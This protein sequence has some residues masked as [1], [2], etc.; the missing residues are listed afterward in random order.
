MQDTSAGQYE[1]LH[2]L[3]ASW[4]GHS[5]T[6][7]LV[8]DP[9]QSIYLFRQARV[10]SFLQ[11]LETCRLGDLPLTR[12]QLTAN[13][14]SQRSLVDHFNRD[15]ALVFPD[16]D[17]LP[18]SAAE[19][20][21]PHSEHASGLKW[22]TNPV[23]IRPALP[24][25]P[26]SLLTPAQLRQRQAKRDACE[27]RRIIERW[28][29]KRLPLGREEPWKIAVLVRN[30]THLIE[31]TTEFDKDRPRPIPYRAID[32]VPLSVRQEVLDLTALT[33]TLLHPADRVAG[34]AV[35]RAPWCG[36]S[37]ADLHTLTGADDPSLR[38][39]SIRRLMSDRGHQLPQESIDRLERTWTVL[40]SV[41]TQRSRLSTARLVERAWRSLG[42]DTWHSFSEARLSNARRF[43][44]LLDEMDAEATSSGGALDPSRIA[45]RLPGLWAETN[46]C[47]PDA[48]SV[49]LLTIHRAK[50]LEWDVVLV[51]ALERRPGA[52]RSRLVTWSELDDADSTSA[53]GAPPI[54]L[55]PIA[56]KGEDVDLLTTW[57]KDIHKKRET[58]E[59]KRIFYVASTRAREELHLFAAPDLTSRGE[60]NPGPNSL[61]RFA[62]AAAKPHFDEWERSRTFD[63]RPWQPPK[64]PPPPA[65]QTRQ[66]HPPNLSFST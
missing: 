30:R 8:G 57:I 55:A 52:S 14:R 39:F 15:F 62:W 40:D 26:E 18:Y 7:F 28:S 9:R 10:E 50:G 54:L 23:E 22:H 6:V 60:L 46:P 12:L 4:D 17:S 47:P 20:I 24:L 37:L 19:A 42:G 59:Y 61:L 36:L 32:I 63:R 53:T 25:P 11:T 56:A 13:F 64:A 27:M 16:V 1:L 21:V 65:P 43:F 29:R 3:T 2:L 48:P 35:L 44:R 38:K 45:D 66:T 5:Q 51:P 34:L 58:A 31:I 49:E 41:A 33:R